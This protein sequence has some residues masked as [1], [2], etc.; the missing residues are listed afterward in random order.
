M[1]KLIRSLAIACIFIIAFKIC[2]EYAKPDHK[3]VASIIG[4]A[5]PYGNDPDYMRDEV[6]LLETDSYGRTFYA[7]RNANAEFRIICQMTKDPFAYYYPDVCYLIESDSSFPNDDIEWLKNVNDWNKPLDEG[8]MASVNY[9]L[10]ETDFD[11]HYHFIETAIRDTLHCADEKYDIAVDGLETC[12]HGS[13][14][15]LVQIYDASAPEARPET[16]IVLCNA[17]NATRP[18]ISAYRKIEAGEN[19][20]ECIIEFKSVSCS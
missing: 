4:I 3:D 20:R 13:Q 15:I 6:K 10:A 16:Y 14:Y 7:Y 12:S 9:I 1:K 5:V 18:R 17:Y 8:K 2:M 11:D 19:L